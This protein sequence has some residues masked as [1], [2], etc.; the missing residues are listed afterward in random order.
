MRENTAKIA[1][2][3]STRPSR[4]FELG[5]CEL[6][7]ASSRSRPGFGKLQLDVADKSR[8]V[9][10]LGIQLVAIRRCGAN[11]LDLLLRALKLCLK[12][13]FLFAIARQQI[14]TRTYKREATE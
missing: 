7:L 5:R 2:Q 3:F 9:Y 13:L 10:Y 14:P 6:T 8:R 11:P 12:F 4:P 1:E